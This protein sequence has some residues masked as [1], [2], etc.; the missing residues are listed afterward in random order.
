ML[1]SHSSL[2][3]T[4]V[5]CL[6]R[7]KSLLALLDFLQISTKRKKTDIVLLELDKTKAALCCFSWGDSRRGLV[8]LPLNCGFCSIGIFF[9]FCLRFSGLLTGVESIMINVQGDLKEPARW[10]PCVGVHF[11]LRACG[12]NSTTVDYT[13]TVTDGNSPCLALH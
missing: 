1:E 9:R 12:E 6:N 13:Q 3:Q 11:E 10:K 7:D 4:K 5:F 2:Y 8:S